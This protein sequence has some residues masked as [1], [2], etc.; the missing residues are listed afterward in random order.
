MGEGFASKLSVSHEVL[1][2][3][4]YRSIPDLAVTSRAR[5]LLNVEQGAGWGVPG[6]DGVGQEYRGG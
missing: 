3:A 6:E 2:V 4:A 1:F 5:L